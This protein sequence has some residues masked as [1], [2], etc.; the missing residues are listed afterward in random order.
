MSCV[1]VGDN[2]DDS[3][4][5]DDEVNEE[6]DHI[7]EVDT[8]D[9]KDT[10]APGDEQLEHLLEEEADAATDTTTNI[11]VEVDGREAALLAASI[12][13]NDAIAQR[14]LL[15]QMQLL[16]QRGEKNQLP[17][18]KRTFLLFF[19]YAQ[20]VQCPFYGHEQPGETYY[21][22]PLSIS[23]FGI[24]NA[25]GP[26]ERLHAYCYHEGKGKKGGN[27]VTSM[28]HYYLHKELKIPVV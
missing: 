22:S 10:E 23:V 3:L 19:D 2:D 11:E 25:C 8:A 4:G 9:D 21:F 12:H 13:I 24:T 26:K 27:N 28:L 16:A 17:S 7:V 15:A 18:G 6:D 20:N 14:K 5:S 1:E